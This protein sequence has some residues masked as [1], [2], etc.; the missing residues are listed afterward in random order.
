MSDGIGP[1]PGQANQGSGLSVVL[2][3]VVGLVELWMI[4][5]V[6]ILAAAFVMGLL[7]ANPD[8]GFAEWI[9]NRTG[10]IMTPFNGLFE[11]IELTGDAV[12]QTSLLFAILVYGVLAAVLSAVG[13]RI[14][15]LL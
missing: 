15:S 8:A 9:Y 1:R 12:V 14:A 4:I 6:L 11:P 7:G 10:E 13:R 5:M 2:R 3:I